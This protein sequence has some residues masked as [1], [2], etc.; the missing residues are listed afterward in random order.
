MVSNKFLRSSSCAVLGA[1]L[2]II[3]RSAGGF[4]TEYL[5]EVPKDS[6]SNMENEDI[7]DE[8][9]DGDDLEK[10]KNQ[11][12]KEESVNQKNDYAFDQN[13]EYSKIEQS[14][15][16]EKIIFYYAIMFLIMVSGIKY[17]ENEKR[18]RLIKEILCCAIENSK[19]SPEEI[20]KAAGEVCDLFYTQHDIN[21]VAESYKEYFNTEKLKKFAKGEKIED[22]DGQSDIGN[23]NSSYNSNM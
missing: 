13:E 17:M 2:V 3:A 8:T 19:H 15:M 21:E 22:T 23:I 12:S 20:N 6:S 4:A 5:N 16:K 1:S 11:N 14:S 9:K 10:E 18:E 7:F